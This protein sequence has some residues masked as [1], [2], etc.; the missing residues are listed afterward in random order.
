MLSP[1]RPKPSPYHTKCAYRT[2]EHDLNRIY[3]PQMVGSARSLL[4]RCSSQ[5]VIG[6]PACAP[7]DPSGMMRSMSQYHLRASARES[8]ALRAYCVRA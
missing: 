2:A 5:R 8:C 7:A 6:H 1:C 4:S 3:A